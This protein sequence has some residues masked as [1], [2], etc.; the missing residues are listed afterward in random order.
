MEGDGRMAVNIGGRFTAD[1]AGNLTG[2]GED[3]NDGNANVPVSQP[4]VGTYEI[5]S[6]NRGIFKLKTSPGGADLGTFRFA[7]GSISG[8][9]A[10]KARFVEFDTHSTRGGGVIEKQDPTAFSTAK[11]TGDYAFGVSSVIPTA[12]SSIA[13][14]CAAGRFTASAGASSSGAIDEDTVG[15]ITFN[16]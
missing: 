10:S 2:G 7:V 15:P 1:G 14:F 3:I 8:G 13:N 5:Y 12:R 6:D 16:P 9:V 11:I 4:F